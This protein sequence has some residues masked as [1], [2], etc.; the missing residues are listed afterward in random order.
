MELHHLMG[1][2]VAEAA[3][4]M[5]RTKPAVMGLLFRALKKLREHLAERREDVP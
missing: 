2:S 4:V 1:C 5:Q 3:E